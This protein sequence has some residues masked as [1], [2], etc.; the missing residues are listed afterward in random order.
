MKLPWRRYART[1]EPRQMVNTKAQELQTAKEILAEVFQI[2]PAEVDEMLLRRLTEPDPH[3]EYQEEL[4]PA[5]FSL[6][7]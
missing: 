2:R 5:T 1:I 7:E 6:G 4:W 3:N